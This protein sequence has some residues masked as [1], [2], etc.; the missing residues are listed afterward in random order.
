LTGRRGRRNATVVAKEYASQQDL[1]D[2]DLMP[3]NYLEQLASEWYEFQGYFVRRNVRVGRRSRGGHEGE[4]DI[5]GFRPASNDAG[6]ALLH[7]ETSMDADSWAQREAKFRKKFQV[8]ER[9]IR[10]LFEGLALPD[11]VIEKVVI[12]GFGSRVR[13]ETIGGAK[14]LLLEDLLAEILHKLK[15]LSWW[16]H[17]IPEG[18][19]I[20][21]TLQVVAAYGGRLAAVLAEGGKP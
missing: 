11:T 10:G 6:A 7:V 19:P 18:Y 17:S 12:L 15:T 8:G 2:G 4:L 9:Y 16:S 20:L 14:I 1:E 5:V 13:H 3:L 21:R